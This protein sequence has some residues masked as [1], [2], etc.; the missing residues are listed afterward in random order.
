MLWFRLTSL[1]LLIK[2]T[3]N[4]VVQSRQGGVL[5]AANVTATASGMTVT[6]D[7]NSNFFAGDVI[8]VTSTTGVQG[9]SAG[10]PR[11]WQFRTSATGSG[12]FNDSGQRLEVVN[13]T[14]SC[15]VELGDLDG[16][17][18]LDIFAAN[19]GANR[20]YLNDSTGVFSDSGQGLGD[21]NS[22]N[23]ALGDVDGDGDLDAVVSNVSTGQANRVWTNNGSGVFTSADF[24]GNRSFD[25]MLGDLDA[26]GDLDAF[27]SNNGSANR[28]YRNNGA[29]VFTDTG[30]GIS[31]R[32]SRDAG[33]GDID[34]DGDLDVVVSNGDEGERVYLNDGTGMF[35]DT[36]QAFPNVRSRGV[37][38]GDFDGDGDLDV[39]VSK[40]DYPNSILVN[41]TNTGNPGI[42]T[43]SGQRLGDPEQF[44]SG[45]SS[46]EGVKL[47]DLDGDGDLDAFVVNNVAQS[48]ITWV[49]DG[50]GIFTELIHGN[51]QTNSI[52][53]ALGDVDGDGD[54]D[55][56]V[57]NDNT[58]RAA[59]SATRVWINQ[60]LTPSVTLSIDNPA[61][62]EAGG[63]ATVTAT[64]SAAHTDP[65]TVNLGISGTATAT[66]DY[67]V[68]GTQIAIAAGATSGS[69]SVT[70]VQDAVDEPN[71]TVIVEITNIT[72]GQGGGSVTVTITDDDEP[73]IPDVTLAVDNAEIAEAGGV[74]TFAATL[75]EVTTVDVTINLAISGTA[76][77]SDFTASA[78]QVVIGAGST[79]GS[80]TV[81]AVDDTENESDETVI[82]DIDSV[83][84]GNESGA[85]Q[86]TTTIVDDDVPPSLRVSTLTA[87]SMG[88]VAEFNGDLNADVLNLYD[89]ASAGLGPADATLTG[90]SSGPIAGSM[91]IEGRQITF[92]KTGG[93]LAA[94]TYTVALRSGADGFVSADG[95]MLLDGDG[96]GTGGDAFGDTFS[97]A[98]PAAGSVTV[99][100]P[101]FVRG[102]GQDVN[103]PAAS[104]TGIPLSLSE[105]ATVRNVTLSIDYDPARL[106]I[107]AGSVAAGMPVGAAVTLDTSVA[108]T[109]VVTFTSPADLPAGETNFVNLTAAVPTDNANAI[110]RSQQV[111]DIHSISITDGTASAI[112]SID[113]DGLHVA[114]Y[115]ADVSGNGR[116]NASDAAQV[117]RVAALL[118]GGF[119]NTPNSD[120][121][122]VGDV[123]GNGRIN[124]ADASLVAQVAAL[125]P[126]DQVPEIPSGVVTAT[127]GRGIQVPLNLDSNDNQTAPAVAAAQQQD[128]ADSVFATEFDSLGNADE[129]LQTVEPT[130]SNVDAALG[131]LL[132][133]DLLDNDVANGLAADLLRMSE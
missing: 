61:I 33:M 37:V 57:G 50:A 133:D 42:F 48:N 17:G 55:A 65:V 26:D 70:A 92:I 69:V 14:R 71:E 121:I 20:V 78:T 125:I 22:R 75:S 49:N 10:V 73:P 122:V 72:N 7:P 5:T 100:L 67:T 54:L 18:D 24:G 45:A 25:V 109:A 110:Y 111:L 88:F 118:D 131:E 1:R 21:Y 81:T 129:D 77:A 112:P 113:D 52:D 79:S 97:I 105:G 124:A 34:G 108:G 107:T 51:I 83:T 80:I 63:V 36:G 95:N 106:D 76:A 11:V 87:T 12:I 64:L 98:T 94:D 29:G 53:V 93:P 60:T 23:I 2:T 102:P 8:Q 66:D 30:Q 62:A 86:A 47:A 15:G 9:T 43:E 116:A 115:L 27:V 41:Q 130:T 32:P 82:V 127:A 19:F 44:G 103:L 85:Q 119:A 104:T 126:V 38:L 6:L 13:N 58:F 120:P 4:L 99:S 128:V 91:V 89:T 59:G 101:D 35:T 68:S 96:D 56:V 28:V 117:A 84:N 123:S 3:Q 40:N 46:S 74:A 114:A 31:N 90:A 132:E 39:F 16:D